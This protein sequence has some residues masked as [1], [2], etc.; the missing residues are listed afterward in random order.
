[1]SPTNNEVR[2]LEVELKTDE[3]LEKA[4]ELT[5]KFKARRKA[6][7]R[8]KSFNSQIKSE[9]D[10]YDADINILS[11]AINTGKEFRDVNCYFTD[12]EDGITRFWTRLDTKEVIQ[13]R[14]LRDDERQQDLIDDTEKEPNTVEGAEENA[15]T[16]E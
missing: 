9:I 1:M 16:V 7:D 8:K 13:S 3:I 11:E 6:E 14:P 4:K 15:D 12:T 5:T 2:E 10:G